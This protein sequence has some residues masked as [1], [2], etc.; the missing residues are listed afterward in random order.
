MWY[1]KG[2]L[3]TAHGLHKMFCNSRFTTLYFVFVFTAPNPHTSLA[4]G[5]YDKYPKKTGDALHLTKGNVVGN[6][7]P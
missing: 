4:G 5:G 3:W 7:N 2:I 1:Q 6:P